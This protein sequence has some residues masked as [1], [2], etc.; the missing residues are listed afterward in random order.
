MPYGNSKPIKIV[1][2]DNKTIENCSTKARTYR[3]VNQS[4]TK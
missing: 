3:T 1:A 2:T 4:S